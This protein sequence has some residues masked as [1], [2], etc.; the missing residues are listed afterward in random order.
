MNRFLPPAAC[1]ACLVSA[2]GASQGAPVVF[3]IDPDASAVSGSF[4]LLAET[5]GTLIGDYDETTNPGGTQTRPGLFGGSG[6]NPIPVTIDIGSSTGLATA[7]AGSFTLDADTDALTVSIDAFTADLLNGA[8]VESS[9]DL[10][11]L[12][13]TFRTINPGGFYPG[14]IPLPIWLPAG[15]LSSLARTQ[16]A[17]AAPGA[18][19]PNPDGT[20][21]LA[22][23]VPV[24]LTLSGTALGGAAIDPGPVGLLLPLAG[25][26]A[27]AP[28]RSASVTLSIDLDAFSQSVDASGLPALPEI[29]FELPTLGGETASVLLNLAVGAITLEGVGSVTLVA[30]GTPGG[31][32]AADIAEPF[33]VLDLSDLLAFIEAFGAQVEPA[34]YDDN[35]VFDLN[36][37]QLFITAFLGGCP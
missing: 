12:F 4:G 1:A 22:A 15:E 21:T 11:F 8:A 23:A 9:L 33:G 27:P 18:L 14:G 19:V 3:A 13:E 2:I 32:N 17:P 25:T 24:T 7:P 10:T 29:P 5:A 37:I 31:C 6:N 36:D 35:G 34:D 20:F 16:N 30:N 28:D 26:Y